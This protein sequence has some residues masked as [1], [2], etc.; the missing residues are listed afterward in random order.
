[1]L[2]LQPMIRSNFFFKKDVLC[3][4]YVILSVFFSLLRFIFSFVFVYVIF[5]LCFCFLL[6]KLCEFCV[7][8]DDFAVSRAYDCQEVSDE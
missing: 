3:V 1:M 2:S 4:V 5:S 7:E 8:I 6:G